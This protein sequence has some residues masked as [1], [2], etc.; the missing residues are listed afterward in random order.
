MGCSIPDGRCPMLDVCYVMR[1][2]H[3]IRKEVRD[4]SEKL[5]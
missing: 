3:Y 2:A 4:V 1:N 5:Q